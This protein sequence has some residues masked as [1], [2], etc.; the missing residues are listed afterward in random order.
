MFKYP[1]ISGDGG[2][3]VLVL[4]DPGAELPDG[5]WKWWRLVTETNQ[6]VSLSRYQMIRSY[7]QKPTLE[8]LTDRSI[9]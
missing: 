7:K 9:K 6:G 8:E 2:N 4:D 5:D 1:I 3:S